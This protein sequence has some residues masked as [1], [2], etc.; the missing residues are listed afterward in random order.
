MSKIYTAFETKKNQ[1]GKSKT[2]AYGSSREHLADEVK[3]LELFLK[4]RMAKEQQPEVESQYTGMVMLNRE[5]YD[6]LG[7][8]GS[9]NCD[10]NLL[11]DELAKL[12]EQIEKRL[13]ASR[14]KGIRLSLPHVSKMLNLSDFE[15][16]CIIV[17]LAPELD[18]KFE[19]VYAHFQDNLSVQ[20]PSIDMVLKIF[21][22]SEQERISLRT[23]FAP[24][25]PLMRFLME[26]RSDFMDTRVPLI[27]RPIKL[28]DWA[29]NYLLDFEVLDERLVRVAELLPSGGQREDSVLTG[30]EENIVRFMTYYSSH[31]EGKPRQIFY[32][33]GPD[34][35]GKKSHVMAVCRKLGYSLVVADMEK[36]LA[37]DMSFTEMLQLLGRHAMLGNV[38]LCF[39]NFSILLTEDEK[40]QF[41]LHLLMQML[42][43][44]APLTFILSQSS[45]SP[46]L[47]SVQSNFIQ[48]ECPL[49]DERERKAHWE[50]FGQSYKLG[51]DINL[52]DLT[53]SFRFTQGQIQAALHHS[54]SLAVWN[55]AENGLIGEEELYN[56]CYAQSNRK[57]NALATKIRAVYNWDV[58]VLP[59]DQISQLRE[60]CHQVKYRPVVYGDWG[61]ERRLSLGK[62]LNV[63]FSG[64]PGCGKTMAAEVIANELGLE[65]YKIDVSQLVSKYIGETEKNL[66]RI[67]LEAETS[68]A[69]L[70][71]DEADALFG[72]RSE[73][74]DAHD[75]YAN[76]EISYLL[77]KM[78]EYKGIVILATN[79]NQNID[80]AFLR[81]LHFSVEFPFPEK[82]QRKRIWQGMF[83][84]SAP[85]DENIDYEFMADKF[86]LAG[87][88]I[89]NI[90]LN[91]AFYAAHESGAIRMKHIMLAAKRE[92]KKLGKTFLKSDFDPYYQLIEVM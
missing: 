19:K 62:G 51:Q 11:E 70:F 47:L 80:E 85:L 53:G 37:S 63:L 18:R 52:E 43:T 39:E 36:M 78:E 67:F 12:E 64:P 81:R 30:I 32:L 34:G 31:E 7:N 55:G 60:I 83:P 82:E 38:A 26:N 4:L 41:K 24:Q 9:E 66:A 90:A 45:W 49:P 6:L 21:A 40:Y 71:F 79:L 91:A 86:M 48:I 15:E 84:Q 68:N 1:A 69:I 20:N 50:R 77:Q 57:L 44:F 13:E 2:K 58:L 10:E 54:E 35:A 29:V 14:H 25:A 27:A 61:F 65:I 87:G 88:N 16:K 46:A 42:T 59:P 92:Y 28:E 72:K 33:Y 8:D 3:R 23:A 76:L 74:K 75:R 17:C 5:V 22:T 89:K 56:A 73:V